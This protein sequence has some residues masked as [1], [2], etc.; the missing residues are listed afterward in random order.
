MKNNMGGFKTETLL[1]IGAG[2]IASKALTN[3]LLKA[4]KLEADPTET[5]IKKYAPI[6]VKLVAGYFGLQQKNPMI[7]NM[8]L[9][10][11]AAG[12]LEGAETFAPS[13][14]APKLAAPQNLI[15]VNGIGAPV[16]VLDM[17]T[18]MDRMAGYEDTARMAGT[19]ENYI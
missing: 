12:L 4:L 1:Y 2:A 18:S 9:G 5:G 7:K 11:I 19:L 10:A 3:P 14:F 13:V 8:A 15:R 17:G 16:Q 6:A